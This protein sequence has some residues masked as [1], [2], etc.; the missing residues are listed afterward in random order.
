M[1][2]PLTAQKLLDDL[3]EFKDQFPEEM[4]DPIEIQ[5]EDGI[6]QSVAVD[7]ALANGFWIICE[8]QEKEV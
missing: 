6:Y 5:D 3:L 8:T 1:T 4:N 7:T 2:E